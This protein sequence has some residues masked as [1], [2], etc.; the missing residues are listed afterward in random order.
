VEVS[1][2]ADPEWVIKPHIS[3]WPLK[4]NEAHLFEHR[5]DVP[6][7]R[8]ADKCRR[9]LADTNHQ[10]SNSIPEERHATAEDLRP[11]ARKYAALAASAL[12]VRSAGSILVQVGSGYVV[13]AG[14]TLRRLME[15]RMNVEAILGDPSGDYAL[16]FIRGRGSSLKKLSGKGKRRADVEALSPLAH[17]DSRTLRY[18]SPRNAEAEAGSQVVHGEISVAPTVDPQMAE[19]ILYVVAD[20]M[21]RTAAGACEVFGATLTLPSWVASELERLRGLAEEAAASRQIARDGESRSPR[22]I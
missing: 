21:V 22:E 6:N 11:R 7:W 8:L 2:A 13:E 10:L 5:Q 15:A 3:A 16:R 20:E 9:L 18:L 1:G 14:G 4:E 17:A 19:S 12:A